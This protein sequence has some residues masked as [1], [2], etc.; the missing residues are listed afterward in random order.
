MFLALILPLMA[1]PP[2]G[3]LSIDP[4]GGG[5]EPLKNHVLPG[6]HYEITCPAPTTTCP[7]TIT[8][9]GL[10][11][12]SV[13][14]AS[15]PTVLQ[16]SRATPT[17]TMG[18]AVTATAPLV[19]GITAWGTKII[20][21]ASLYCAQGGAATFTSAATVVPP[22]LEIPL[23]RA[24]YG[25][26]TYAT[27]MGKSVGADA[28]PANTPFRLTAQFFIWPKG[29]EQA[30]VRVVGPGIDFSKVYLDDPTTTTSSDSID[31][32]VAFGKDP[33]ALFTASGPGPMKIW[34]EFEGTKSIE[35][36]YTVVA[37]SG[38]TGG[39]AGGTGGGKSGGSGGGGGATTPGGGCSSVGGATG[40]LAL[41]ALRRSTR[42]RS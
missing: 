19:S 30:T 37:S 5:M 17:E 14:W 32:A 7:N 27:S 1:C 13:H 25:A 4:T 11:P 38:G 6:L 21:T 15:E 16:A 34:L 36:P 18:D 33:A 24:K 10:G 23:D 12:Y 40:F 26:T 9:V 35:L 29:S 31:V 2:S 20:A 28:V 41:L 39:G 3:S 8:R 22:F 42:R